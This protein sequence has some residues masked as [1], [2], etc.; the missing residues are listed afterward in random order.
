MDKAIM[1]RLINDLERAAELLE[2]EELPTTHP[3]VDALRKVN[4]VA[5]SL[6]SEHEDIETLIRQCAA[7]GQSKTEARRTLKISHYRF[8]LLAD[9]MPDIEWASGSS[10]ARRRYNE[11]LRGKPVSD[12]VKEALARGRATMTD[13]QRDHVLCGVRGTA[14]ELFRLWSEYVTIS[15]STFNTRLRQGED[16]IPALF[17]DRRPSAVDSCAKTKAHR[18]KVGR[19]WSSTFRPKVN[20]TQELRP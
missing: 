11:N 14:L 7:N 8:N 12:K 17:G 9:A 5:R 15:Y 6:R 3:L 2:N 4:H 18:K 20:Q 19:E 1:A 16:V 13:N 10:L